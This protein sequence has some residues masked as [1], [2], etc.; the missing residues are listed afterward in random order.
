MAYNFKSL[1]DVELLKST[2]DGVNL[3]AEDGGKI[4][5]VAA[6]SLTSESVV[7]W[8]DLTD[9][10]FGETGIKIEWDGNTEG[11]VNAFGDY[12]KVSDNPIPLDAFLSGNPKVYMTL[13]TGEHMDIPLDPGD[14]IE[15]TSEQAWM[16]Y[17]AGILCAF[18]DGASLNEET[19]PEK[20]L[21]LMRS[22]NRWIGRMECEL[23]TPIPEK[24]LPGGGVQ[25][26]SV[27]GNGS[28][29][30]VPVYRGICGTSE[31]DVDPVP[32]SEVVEAFKSGAV[33]RIYYAPS[34]C[35]GT[36]TGYA[37]RWDNHNVQIGMSV[38]PSEALTAM[39][40][41]AE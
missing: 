7:S 23:I 32:A 31:P 16:Y 30:V 4:V 36:M 2:S 21:Y 26:L 37:V 14:Q 34:D 38:G 3:I 12:Y 15:T 5:K 33:V 10:P 24:F 6:E 1:A 22:G 17:N 9:K 40:G 8:N 27:Y 41:P 20:G 25:W 28:E 39:I 13:S 19:I 11:L 35:Y 18:I 29:S